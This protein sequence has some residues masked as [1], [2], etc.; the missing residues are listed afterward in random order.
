MAMGRGHGV[1]GGEK[2]GKGGPS[3]GCGPGSDPRVEPD[4]RV[5][6]SL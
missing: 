1:G 4:S 6:L 3:K 5:T 2:D